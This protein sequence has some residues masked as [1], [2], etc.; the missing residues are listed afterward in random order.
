M[1]FVLS[2]NTGAKQVKF[3]L[4][5]DFLSKFTLKKIDYKNTL[6][7]TVDISEAK[8]V[9]TK[10]KLVELENFPSK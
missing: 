7:L 10:D 3:I 2:L 4:L 1:A 5:K 8:I 6:V 9:Y